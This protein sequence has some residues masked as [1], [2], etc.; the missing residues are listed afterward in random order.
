LR[1]DSK[2]TRNAG[3][4]GKGWGMNFGSWRR[5][6]AAGRRSRRGIES[7]YWLWLL[8]LRASC[9]CVHGR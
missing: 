3:E 8:G 4:G 6:W 1:V 9:E 7:A 2:G 5:A